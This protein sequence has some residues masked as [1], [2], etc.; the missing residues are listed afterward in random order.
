MRRLRWSSSALSLQE[1]QQQQLN[2]TAYSL[3]IS[4]ALHSAFVLALL[5]QL[6]CS[7]SPY[8]SDQLAKP[9]CSSH[10]RNM[11]SSIVTTSPLRCSQPDSPLQTVVSSTEPLGYSFA[12]LIVALSLLPCASNTASATAPSPRRG[13]YSRSNTLLKLSNWVLRQLVYVHCLFGCWVY[14]CIRWIP[15][16]RDMTLFYMSRKTTPAS[17]TCN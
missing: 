17:L 8:F 5:K 6:N 11:V 7:P 1:Q 15:Y 4:L 3:Y 2:A 16:I 9:T 10:D 14:A 13:V 12:K